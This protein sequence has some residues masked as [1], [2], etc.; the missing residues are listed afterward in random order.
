M[1]Q[2]SLKTVFLWTRVSFRRRARAIS[3]AALRD[4]IAALAGDHPHRDGGV[5]GRPELAGARDHVA[6]GLEPLVVLADDD[7]VHV[8]KQR[9]QAGIGAR[10]P[11]IGEQAEM[12]AQDR[13]RVDGARPLADRRGC[14]IGPRMK[15]SIAAS[16]SSVPSGI[17]DPWVSSARRPIGIGR[18]SMSSPRGRRRRAPP[19]PRPA[20][21]RGRYRRRRGCRW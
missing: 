11:D 3:S 4:A 15:P 2:P 9:P 18:Q 16:A 20:R 13:V 10:R 7:Q 21:S 6:V 1:P 19:G 17:V 12:L 14:P 8:V 5:L